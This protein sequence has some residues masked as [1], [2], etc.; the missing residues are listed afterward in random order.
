MQSFAQL[1]KNCELFRD[2]PDEVME[3]EIAPYGQLQ[4]IPKGTHLV[5]AQ[6]K[7]DYFGIVIKGKINIQYIDDNGNFNIMDILEQD[8]FFG[9]DLIYTRKRTSPYHVVASQASQI[10]I[11]PVALFLN[12]DL[13]PGDLHLTLMQRLLQIISDENMRK[14]YRLAILAQKGLRERITTFLSMQAVKRKTDT[15]TVPFSRNEMAAYLCVNRTS[16]SHELSLMEQE[17]I[18]RFEKS[19]FTLLQWEFPRTFPHHLGEPE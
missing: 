9:L 15:F 16:L 8:D 19:T 17:G 10:L 12:P 18:I 3:K 14:E 5:M 1:L 6:E 13:L 7:L 2:L 11:F 4:S